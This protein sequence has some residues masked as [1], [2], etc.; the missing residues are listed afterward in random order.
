[1]KA[2]LLNGS[3]RKGGNTDV[4]CDE[5]MRGATD[6]GAEC[7]KVALDDLG[8]RPAGELGDVQVARVDVRAG[9]DCRMVLDKVLA[10]DIVVIA[11]PV[12]W[13]GITAQL[14]CFVD[15]F[16]CH[17]A[18][19]WFTEGM[20]GKGWAVITPFGASDPSEADWIIKPVQ[21]WVQHFKGTYLG[22]VA[23]SVFRKGAV[24]ERPEVLR[25][26]YELGRRAVELMTQAGR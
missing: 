9:D 6:A 11:S 8:I 26:A 12:Y 24:R 16:S 10:A 21:V 17:Y 15:R 20:R 22:E 23:V 14:K 19:P 25:E 13:Q 4:L 2:I 3:P 18:Q 5:F 7:E 1:M